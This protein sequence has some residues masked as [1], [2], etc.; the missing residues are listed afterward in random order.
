MSIS[1]SYAIDIN[2]A[3]MILPSERSRLDLE[4]KAFDP[5]LSFAQ[6]RIRKPQCSEA[7]ER[8]ASNVFITQIL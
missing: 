4:D 6:T 1:S 5:T 3:R 2:K 7:Q 8:N